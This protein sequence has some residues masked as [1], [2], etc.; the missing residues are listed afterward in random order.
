MLVSAML[1]RPRRALAPVFVAAAIALGGCQGGAGAQGPRRALPQYQ[2]HATELF[3]DAIE[4]QAVGLEVDRT[5][6]PKGDP[7]LRERTQTADAVVRVRIT[8]VT[9]KQEDSGPTY[10]IGFRVLDQITGPH[11]PPTEFQIRLSPR[12]PA[13]GIVKSFEDRL[14]T[15]KV[16]FL[17]FVRGFT[18][19][20]DVDGE[21]HFHLSPDTKEVLAA[22]MEAATL[23]ELK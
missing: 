4:P 16:T 15:M 23:A 22:V 12:S 13:V 9:G 1:V 8:T 19:P 20:D 11:P 5:R 6:P 3:D 21:I 7:V 17:A 10:V 18:K 14:V 2:G